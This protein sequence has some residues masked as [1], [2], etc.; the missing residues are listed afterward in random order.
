M[1]T[2]EERINMLKEKKAFI[3]A[4]NMA[5]QVRPRK[6]SVR[7]VAYEVFSKEINNEF[8][9]DYLYL[10]EYLVVTF[11]GG[12]ISVCSA[13]GNS[14]TANFR[15]LGKLLDGGYYDEVELYNTMEER[16]FTKVNLDV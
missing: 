15:E 3:D 7:S 11:D 6:Q 12:G 4:L 10:Q 2:T 5:F 1:M 13:N 14:N 8:V 16:G 9:T